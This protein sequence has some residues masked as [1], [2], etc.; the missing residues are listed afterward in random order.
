MGQGGYPKNRESRYASTEL[1]IGCGRFGLN[2]ALGTDVVLAGG[3]TEASPVTDTATD[4]KF[5]SFYVKSSYAGGT[6]R[7]IYFYLALTGGA[8]GEAGRFKTVVSNNTPA[9]TVN[10]V[11]CGLDFGASAGNVTGQGSAG[12]FTIQVPASRT[13]GGTVAV[14]QA[15]LETGASSVLSNT[16]FIR[17]TAMGTPG[18]VDDYAYFFTIDGLTDADNHLFHAGAAPGTLTGS[19]RVKVNSTTYYLP[20]YATQQ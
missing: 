11:H 15:D 16:S 18:V 7:G 10:A 17:C 5:M 19:L 1:K 14:L 9:D 2:A 20:L 4:P 3:G 6:A 13:L 8:G 12:R